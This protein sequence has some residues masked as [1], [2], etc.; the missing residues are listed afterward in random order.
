[1]D[2]IVAI[3]DIATGEVLQKLH[4]H[5]GHVLALA[6]DSERILSAGGDNTVRYWQWGKKSGPTDKYHVLDKG[7]TLLAV[8]K[9]HGLTLEE[10]MRWNGVTEMKQTYTGESCDFSSIVHV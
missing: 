4:G 7:E 2:N 3:T 9:L 6:F 8:S 10:L 5:T 1:M